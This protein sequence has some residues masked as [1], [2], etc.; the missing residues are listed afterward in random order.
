MNI[1]V[2]VSIPKKLPVKQLD[3]F[4]DRTVYNTARI[5]LDRTHSHIPRLTGNMERDIIGYGVRGSNKTYALGFS[6]ANYAPIVWNYP[7]NRTNWTNPRSYSKWFITEF[8]NSKEQI[9]HQAV[10]QALKV[11]K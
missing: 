4:V 1:G 3:N 9:T 8:K 11:I 7:Q 10:N 5:T 6:S 2:S